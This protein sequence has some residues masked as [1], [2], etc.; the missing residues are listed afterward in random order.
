M[1]GYIYYLGGDDVYVQ[2]ENGGEG[3]FLYLEN[4]ATENTHAVNL[5]T[6]N[7]V[8]MDLQRQF[9]YFGGYPNAYWVTPASES[10]LSGNL[11]YNNEDGSV[12]RTFYTSISSAITA[13]A[14][15]SSD[16]PVHARTA[17]KRL[18][19]A[20]NPPAKNI[21]FIVPALIAIKPPNNVNITVVIQ[22]SPFE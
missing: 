13:I 12:S 20:I 2:D 3:A 7:T 16:F 18:V 17:N 21:V 8:A 15:K 19:T 4:E 5:S 9:K 14:N 10:D 1:S 6:L 11:T 22:P